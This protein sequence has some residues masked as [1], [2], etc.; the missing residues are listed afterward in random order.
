[1]AKCEDC[2]C[3]KSCQAWCVAI[4]KAL[5]TDAATEELQKNNAELC[6]SFKNT[7]D[8]VWVVRCKDCKHFGKNKTYRDTKLPISF[9]DKF[10]HNITTENDFCSYGERKESEV[11]TK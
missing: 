11:D 9:C 5:K 7:A 1:M 4:D 2:I 6:P 10:H 3:F 8:V